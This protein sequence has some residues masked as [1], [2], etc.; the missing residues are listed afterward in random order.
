MRSGILIALALLTAS[1]H[2]P[3]P[4]SP[5]AMAK[6]P[7]RL[8]WGDT[9]LHTSHSADAYF[10]QNRSAGPDTAYRW[11]KGL[12]VVHPSTRSRVQIRT[13]LD[14]LVVADPAEMLGLPLK[15]MNGD[16]ELNA[17]ATGRKWASMMRA[18]RGA[19]VFE[20]EFGAAINRNRPIADF[21]KDSIK[22]AAWEDI[23]AAATRHDAPCSFTSFIGW[24]W[25]STEDG[26]NLHRNVLYRDDGDV[27]RRMVP[28]TTAES[29]NPEELWKWM[30]RYED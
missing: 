14:F 19:E 17:T 4:T 7:T 12:P 10:L 3:P 26:N 25:T 22:Q 11:A 6:E 23:I 8:Y 28:Y 27:A 29:F 13:P 24:E 2:G 16:P 20:H 9:H 30:A 5:G 18:G 15:L 21:D 1:C